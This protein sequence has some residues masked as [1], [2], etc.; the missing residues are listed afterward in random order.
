VG[1]RSLQIRYLLVGLCLLVSNALNLFIP[2]QTGIIMDSLSGANSRNTWAEVLIF[3]GL[4]FAASDAGIDMLR[5]WLW[6]PVE[7]YS[8]DAL[9]TAAYAHIMNL[10]ADFHDSKSSSDIMMAI[11]GGQTI[12]DMVEKICF[13]VVPMIVDLIVAV[14]YLSV[15]FG[16][17]EGLITIATGTLFLYIATRL[18]YSMKEARRC[19]VSASFEEHYVRQAGIQGWHTVSSF[20]QIDYEYKRYSRAVKSRVSTTQ[21]VYLRWLIAHG[22]QSL[23]LLCG[24]LAGAFLAVHRIK[25]GKA[26]AGQFAMLLMYWAQLTSPLQFFAMLGKTISNNFIQAERLLDIMKTKPSVL[27]KPGA[28]PLKFVA[29][30]VEFEDV[31]FTYDNKKQIIKDVTFSVPAG[32]VV[33]FV[34][35]TGAGKS[36]IL[37][38]LNRFYDVTAGSIRIDG[39]DIRDVD[40]HR[41]GFRGT[42]M[43]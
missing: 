18:L 19:Q 12:S 15:T 9:S 5:L 22:F 14:V 32:Q 4:K 26:T 29:G 38:L 10:S 17:Y 28:R 39:Q 11:H 27:S 7:F 31:G 16:S 23:C 20:N 13:Y 36:T 21:V 37:K 6:F 43:N 33:A 30:A 24:L 1:N 34:G 42:K 35:A 40:L 8:L 25:T 2:R 3:A 41:Y